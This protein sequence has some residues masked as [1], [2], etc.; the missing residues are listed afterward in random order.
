VGHGS[1]RPHLR[2]HRFAQSEPSEDVG[3]VDGFELL[4]TRVRDR[5][6]RSL[7]AR[8]INKD[9]DAAKFAYRL[10]N[11]LTKERFLAYNAGWRNNLDASGL[12]D[13]A[14][15]LCIII[16]DIRVFPRLYAPIRACAIATARPMP[17]SAPVMSARRPLSLP[18]PWWLCSP[19]LGL[20][21]MS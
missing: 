10:A 17:L 9:I 18:K 11:Q 19:W 12:D 16:F 15:F 8:G 6:H 14:H 2:K 20:G 5:A 3:A 13:F 7:F 1:A 21:R 4:R